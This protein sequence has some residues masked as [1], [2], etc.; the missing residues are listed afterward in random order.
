LLIS[1]LI[2]GWFSAS[3]MAG[4]TGG[5]LPPDAPAGVVLPAGGAQPSAAGPSTAPIDR[6]REL[7]SMDKERQKQIEGL[8][9]R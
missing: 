3:Y 6:A 8:I 1:L 5:S 9:E 7:V 2:V 4:I